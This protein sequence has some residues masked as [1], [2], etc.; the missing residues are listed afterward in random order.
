MESIAN[1]YGYY[2]KQTARL[3]N[4]QP[5]DS[6]WLSLC[7]PQ[8]RHSRSLL[9]VCVLQIQTI[10]QTRPL[11]KLLLAFARLARRK[12][13][14]NI[15]QVCQASRGSFPASSSG[16]TRQTSRRVRQREGLD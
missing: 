4:I 1:Q 6:T 14:I 8:Q 16:V 13:H 5:T 15:P 7:L 3:I 10:I 2:L 9:S 12:R 11:N